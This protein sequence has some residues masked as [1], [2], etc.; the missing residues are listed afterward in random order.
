MRLSPHTAPGSSTLFSVAPAVL[1]HVAASMHHYHINNPVI[2]VVSIKVMQMGFFRLHEVV[3][4]NLS[5]LT[6][7]TT[8]YFEQPQYLLPLA[9]KQA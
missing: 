5:E 6:A 9:L 2:I 4:T 1:V 7:H 3:S 8:A